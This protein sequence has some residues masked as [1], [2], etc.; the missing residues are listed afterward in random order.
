M[1]K[2]V[3]LFVCLVFASSLFSCEAIVK[4]QDPENPQGVQGEQGLL[5]TNAEPTEEHTVVDSVCTVCGKTFCSKG[6]AYTLNAD[7]ASYSITGIGECTDTE[8]MIP[9]E[10]NGLPVT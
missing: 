6:L 1:K 8:I 5:G 2:L 9:S 3:V 10:Y 4:P 7:G